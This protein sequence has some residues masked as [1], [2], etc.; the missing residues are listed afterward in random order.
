MNEMSNA[1]I[2][3]ALIY[4]KH[5]DGALCDICPY[6]DRGHTCSKQLLDDASNRITK[7]ESELKDLERKYSK[8]ETCFA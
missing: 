6:S 7:L 4:C 3:K 2:C 5:S 8:K 1:D